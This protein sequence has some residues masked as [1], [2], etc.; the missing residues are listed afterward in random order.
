VSRL[1]ARSLLALTL[2]VGLAGCERLRDVKR[3]R[4]LA[5]QI[6]ASLDGI[7]ETAT[8]AGKTPDAYRRIAKDYD[9]LAA[10]LESFDAGSPEL[11]KEVGEYAALARSSARQAA[12]LGSAL[13]VDNRAAVSG[14][15]HDLE[16]LAR[17][18]K[19]L[20]SRIDDECKPK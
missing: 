9:G 16:R 13:A 14:A 15:T 7:E 2:L 5:Q 3:C 6:N 4:A 11:V 18:E 17:H 12:A 8:T 1:T 20:V 10:G 19:S